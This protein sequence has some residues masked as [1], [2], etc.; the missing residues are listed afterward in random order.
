[1]QADYRIFISNMDAVNV[2]KFNPKLDVYQSLIDEAVKNL[3]ELTQEIQHKELM[4][5]VSELR[6]RIKDPFMFVVVGEVKAGKS[7]FIN[8]LLQ[9]DREICKVAPMPMTDTIQ[10]ILYGP[11]E[12]EVFINPFF[13]RIFVPADILKEIAIVD[14][15]GTNTIVAHHQEITERFIPSSDL[16]VFVFESKNPYRQSAWDFFDFIKEEWHKKVIF[17]LQQKDLLPAEDL[18]INERGVAEYA[19]KKGIKEA[20][21]FSVSAKMA[22]IIAS[23][24]LVLRNS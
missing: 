4:Q 1:M 15:P 2:F 5:T 6:G 12:Q 10:Q 13:K 7:S 23:G 3:H 8:A 20:R 24:A 22:M 17:I 14:T 9:S 19:E 18:A 21:I 11:E 16:I